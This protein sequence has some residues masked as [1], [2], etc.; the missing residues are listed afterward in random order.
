MIDWKPVVLALLEFR[1]SLKAL[2]QYL[3][4]LIRKKNTARLRKK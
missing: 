3:R 1:W 2:W 4:I